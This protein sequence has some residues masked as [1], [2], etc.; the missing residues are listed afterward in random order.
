[1]NFFYHSR[2]SSQYVYQ[3]VKRMQQVSGVKAMSVLTFIQ[4]R[5]ICKTI[6]CQNSPSDIYNIK[7]L[8]NKICINI[9]SEV[10]TAVTMKNAV[11]WDVALCIYFVNRR[12]GG[13]NR[14][15]LQGIKIYEL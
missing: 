15:H 13:M 1:M 6:E 4:L 11:F 9:T 10:F 3:N 7:N 2:T 12:F 8:K 14:L 5:F